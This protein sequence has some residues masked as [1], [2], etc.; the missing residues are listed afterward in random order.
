MK[1]T[2]R[3]TSMISIV[4]ICAYA[5]VVIG[6]TGKPQQ[7]LIKENP[8]ELYVFYFQDSECVGTYESIIDTELAQSRIKRKSYWEYEELQLHVEVGC[9]KRDSGIGFVFVINVAFGKPIRAE[10]GVTPG[11]V[12]TFYEPFNYGTFGIVGNDGRTQQFIR[13]SLRGSMEKALTD[14]LKANFDL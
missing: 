7:H 6:Q 3:I 8:N 11:W 12:R 13:N 10:E 5:E 14:Y 4:V 1:S 2:I 9:L